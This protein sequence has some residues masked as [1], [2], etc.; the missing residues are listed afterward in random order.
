MTDID[1]TTLLQEEATLNQYIISFVL[2]NIVFIVAYY[3]R[4][5]TY[6]VQ[7]TWILTL[8]F[9]L[10]AFWDTDYFTFRQAYF[11]DLEDFRDPLYY[12][13]G[14]ISFGSYTI[15]RLL[16][17]GTAL[18]LLKR[19]VDRF[20]I[21]YNVAAYIFTIFF[22][23]TFSYARVS[24]GMAMYFYGLS[25][26]IKPNQENRFWSIVWGLIFVGCS[27]YGHRSLMALI[28]LTPLAF[29]KLNKKS[30]I[31]I[32]VIGAMLSGLAATLLSDLISGT[33]LLSDDFG[34]AGEAAEKY[35]NIEMELEYNWK[36]ALVRN[37]RFYSFYIAMAYI[38][39][40]MAFSRD[41]K[42][43]SDE[44]KRLAT[45]SLGILIFAVSFIVL[46]SW[47]AE[48]IGYRYLYM[49]GIPVC[50]ILSYFATNGISKPRTIFVLLLLAFLYSEGFIFGK[51][52]SM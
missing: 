9:C 8:I 46:P 35:A 31:T 3:N 45:I 1:L 43:I 16:I 21:S 39:W 5:K 48:T 50:L 24:L 33:L 42:L 44:I 49:L 18:Y 13:I 52:L 2:M 11:T 15:F 6:P 26:L 25:F 38:A 14:E 12:Y 30:F 34:A 20:D 22:L 51:I 47:G 7:I 23:L 40:K 19:T 36:F 41:S 37:L 10:Y 29:V 28:L 17:W 32:V 4:N 27:Y